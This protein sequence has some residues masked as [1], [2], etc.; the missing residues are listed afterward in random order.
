MTNV[1]TLTKLARRLGFKPATVVRVDLDIAGRYL[2]W[3]GGLGFTPL[4]WTASEARS[5]LRG[6][7]AI[8]EDAES[9]EEL[10]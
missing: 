1:E 6:L 5:S 7:A 10:A 2:L 3:N 9:K 4:G 8:V